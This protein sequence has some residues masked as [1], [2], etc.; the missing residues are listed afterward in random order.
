[1]YAKLVVGNSNLTSLGGMRDIVRLVTSDSPSL[2]NISSF[3]SGSSIIVDN[4]PAGWSYVGST[5]AAD[6]PTP[7]APGSSTTMLGDTV[8]NFAIQAPIASNAS[9]YKYAVLTNA[10]R[11]TTSY[12]FALTGASSASSLGVITNEGPRYFAASGSTTADGRMSNVAGQFLAGRTFHVIA[13][14][15]HCT[16]IDDQKGLAAVWETTQTDAHTFYGTAP[17]VQYSHW[18]SA[19][20]FLSGIIVPTTYT[21]STTITT[22]SAA[23]AFNVTD[24]N[25]G[26]TYGTLD[27]TSGGTTNFGSLFQYT[28]GARTQTINTVGSPRY[29]IEPVH[30]ML[31]SNGYPRQFV[32]GV[33]PIYWANGQMGNTGDSVDVNG[34]TYTFFQAGTGF[35]VIMK[36]T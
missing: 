9:V 14:P 5:N 7:A 29:I 25:S 20:G 18:N 1:M 23:I 33:V 16:I 8:Y 11:T 21:S 35:G 2:A 22:T 10:W 36:L 4:T 32:T 15:R 31:T 3:N 19:Y 30:Y 12:S 28:P 27:V 13:T 24:P 26:T 34:D 6:Q 17:F